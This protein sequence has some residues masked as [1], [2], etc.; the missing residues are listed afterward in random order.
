MKPSNSLKILRVVTN[1]ECVVW[2]M[3]KT[4]QYLA[5]DYEVIVTGDNVSNNSDKFDNVVWKDV[6]IIRKMGLLSDLS[7]LL[8]LYL[9]CKDLK[10]QI[11]HSIMPKAGL[12]AAVAS[13]LANVPIRIHTFT[14]QVWDTKRGFSRWFLKNI[15]RLIVSLN[16]VCLTDSPSQSKHLLNNGIT[17]HGSM[18][19]VLGQGSL[20]GV[21]LDRFSDSR[22]RS[23]SKITRASL[24]LDEGNFVIAF[25]ARK[26]VDKGAIDMLR[27]F[28]IAH[29]Q[30]PH[31]RLLF[32]GPDESCG[33]IDELR[34]TDPALFF[35]VI[36]MG[37]VTIHE[38]YL[39]LSNL[40]CVPSFREGFGTIVLDAA[41]LGVPCVGSRISG[42][43]DS[44][45]DGVTGVLYPVGNIDV[46]ATTL[47]ELDA[48]R[49]RLCCLGSAAKKRAKEV[50]SSDILYAHLSDFY[51]KQ[52]SLLN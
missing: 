25:I 41:A 36:E 51:K 52:A 8:Q 40:L 50:F 49:T 7:A 12:L 46:L 22:I 44:V 27:A 21:D 6:R 3:G 28:K 43:V 24:N 33:L 5:S 16:T 13:R 31:L 19:G 47:L 45:S 37:Q 10:P 14:G 20:I 18:L 1:S 26:S 48:D 29:K 39:L 2:H 9:L 32:I 23:Y 11:V 34:V 38:E 35:G 42:L 30:A 15:D 4:L 17:D